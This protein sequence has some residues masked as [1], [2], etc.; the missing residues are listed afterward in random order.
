MAISKI[1]VG[2]TQH[3]LTPSGMATQT[4]VQNQ[5]YI[6]SHQDIS[7]KLDK[8]QGSANV[9]KYLTVGSDG[10]VTLTTLPVFDGTVV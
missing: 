4:W 1:S 10:Q 9:G 3:D 8:N 5:G 2:G 6:T 7:G